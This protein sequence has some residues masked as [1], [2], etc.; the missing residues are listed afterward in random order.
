[1]PDRDAPPSRRADSESGA[2]LILAL[3]YIIAI[4]LVVGALARWAT[5]DLDNTNN[6]GATSQLHYAVTSAMNTAIESIRYSPVPATTPAQSTANHQVPT[7]WGECWVPTSGSVSQ[8]SFDNNEFVV[9]VYCNVIENNK[10]STTRQVTFAA[11][12]NS[13]TAA[14][15]EAAPLLSAVVN[16]DDYTSG[17]SFVLQVQCNDVPVP[18]GAGQ[19]LKSWIWI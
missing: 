12:L 9:D 8:L 6:F 18:C 10:S 4:S 16:Y 14:S 1:M 3:V 5:D 2:I 19:S 15:C 11:C 13:Q 7:G 17:G